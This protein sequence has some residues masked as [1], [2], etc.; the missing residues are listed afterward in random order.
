M[1]KLF[2]LLS[3]IGIVAISNCSR[4][5]ENNDP[6]LGIW[7]KTQTS[8]IEGKGSSTAREEWIFND[9]YLGRYQSYSNSKLIFYTDF[10]WSEENGT[11]TIIYGDPQVTDITV[12]L[13]HT[14]DPEVLTLENGSVFATRD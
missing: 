8:T 13:E 6:I 14:S 4:I 9:V 3:I 10:K 11:Y 5:P 1:K 2:S 7:A 12:S